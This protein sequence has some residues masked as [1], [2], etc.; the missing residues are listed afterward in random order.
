[1][2]EVSEGDGVGVDDELMGVLMVVIQVS[3][4]GDGETYHGGNLWVF[5]YLWY[6]GIM[7]VHG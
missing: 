6:K 4:G 5:W 2:I 3:Y 1:M 7:V